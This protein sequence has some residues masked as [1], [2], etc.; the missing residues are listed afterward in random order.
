MS[1]LLTTPFYQNSFIFI[2]FWTFIH[3]SLAILLILIISI[4]IRKI[5]RK[6]IVFLVIITLWEI[7][8]F[9]LYKIKP[10]PLLP[11]EP[12]IDV[13]WDFVI[14]SLGAITGLLILN[15]IKK[16]KLSKNKK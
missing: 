2:D 8:E 1:D 14:G 12:L 6:I 7:T 13:I 3:F 9:Y 5:N 11:P 16:N 10:I 15:S 4:F